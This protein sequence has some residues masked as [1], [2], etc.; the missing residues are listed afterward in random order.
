ML[1]LANYI[2]YAVVCVAVETITHHMQRAVLWSHYSDMVWTHS[3]LSATM[4]IS[5]NANIQ[6]SQ[7]VQLKLL[8][9]FFQH[10]DM[11]S[12]IIQMIKVVLFKT[13]SFVREMWMQS[14][15]YLMTEANSLAS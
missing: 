10:E 3:Q 13:N 7:C 9:F 6:F 15:S 12:T 8:N 2:C 11:I 5:V 14:M 1:N 4:E